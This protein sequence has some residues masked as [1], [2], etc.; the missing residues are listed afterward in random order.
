MADLDNKALDL[1][2]SHDEFAKSNF[3]H[4]A[5]NDSRNGLDV[6]KIRRRVDWQIVPLMCM[7]ACLTSCALMSL[8]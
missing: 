5:V 3:Q 8:C 1:V 7:L 4:M 6:R 2:P